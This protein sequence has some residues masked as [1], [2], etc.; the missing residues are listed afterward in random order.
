MDEVSPGDIV[1]S[2]HGTR[3]QNVGMVTSLAETAPKPD[4]GTAGENWSLEGWLVGVEFTELNAPF[5]PKD[6]IDLI[7]PLLPTRY[8]P[9]RANGDGL[10]SVYLAEIP[11]NLAN[12]LIEL[13][14]SAY[15]RPLRLI[16]IRRP[17]RLQKKKQSLRT[18]RAE[19]TSAM[20]SE[21]NSS[22]QGEGK[23]SSAPTFG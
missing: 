2:F 18:S 9:L 13:A 8:S 4:F 22:R 11:E 6:H 12:L 10:Q 14:G 17:K 1:F 7:R 19:Q 5:R 21:P 23:G 3:I 15:P 16:Q 20:S